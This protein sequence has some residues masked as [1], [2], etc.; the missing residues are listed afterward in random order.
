MR[1]LGTL[2]LISLCI[3]A[4]EGHGTI[5][6]MTSTAKN[7]LASL[8]SAQKEKVRFALEDPERTF[9]HYIPSVDVLKK[10]PEK[11]IWAFR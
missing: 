10:T 5:Y 6:M 11:A 9:M 4:H 3:S 8:D 1:L 2:L 7:F